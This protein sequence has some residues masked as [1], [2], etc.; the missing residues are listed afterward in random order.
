MNRTRAPVVITCLGVVPHEIFQPL[1]NH[2]VV[3]PQCAPHPVPDQEHAVEDFHDGKSGDG[4]IMAA[5]LETGVADQDRHHCRGHHADADPGPGA[6]PVSNHGHARAVGADAEEH[7]M[8]E[9]CLAGVTA[10]DVPGLGHGGKQQDQDED[11][12]EKGVGRDYRNGRHQD[13]NR[14]EGQP[15]EIFS[16]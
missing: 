4:E 5:E 8:A 15:E 12:H 2:G 3:Q 9:G 10:D 11:M 6:D 13:Q 14:Q 16:L 7:R 1:L